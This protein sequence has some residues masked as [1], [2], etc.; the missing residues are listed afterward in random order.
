M[1]KR[2]RL[3]GRRGRPHVHHT[4][5]AGKS[6]HAELRYLEALSF[7]RLIRLCR[8]ALPRCRRVGGVGGV[9][10]GDVC[11]QCWCMVVVVE[12]RGVRGGGRGKW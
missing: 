9:A 8:G 6:M 2:G 7:K 4:P 5:T 10:R 12:K 1:G 3:D 11:W